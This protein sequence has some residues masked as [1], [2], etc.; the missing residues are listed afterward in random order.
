VAV[1]GNSDFALHEAEALAPL[2][3]SVTICTNG[4]EPEFT[5]EHDIPVN[6]M[7]IEKIEGEEQVDGIRFAQEIHALEEGESEPTIKKVDGVF[8]AL[9]TAGSAEI[10]RQLGA[11]LTEKGHIQVNENMETS[12]PG[13]Y[14]AGDCTGGLLQV[15]K[16]VYEGAQA[17]LHAIQYVR[18]RAKA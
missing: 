8:V 1:L 18:D 13:L 16:A 7:K 2:V 11:E 10:A 12:I 17:G 15:A 4:K 3:A 6:T 14:A 9:G 5:R